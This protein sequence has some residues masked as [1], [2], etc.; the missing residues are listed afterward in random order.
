[1]IQKWWNTSTKQLVWYIREQHKNIVII[2][3]GEKGEKRPCKSYV[4]TMNFTLIKN[5]FGHTQLIFKYKLLFLHRTKI[6]EP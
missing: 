4:S 5:P 2:S 6:T 1:M 3:N